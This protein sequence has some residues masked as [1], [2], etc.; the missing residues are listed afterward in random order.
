MG[1]HAEGEEPAVVSS[2]VGL[3]ALS[4][5]ATGMPPYGIRARR[6]C[7]RARLIRD[8]FHARRG[9]A[10]PTLSVIERR[11]LGTGSHAEREDA[12][13]DEFASV[14]SRIMTL[15]LF[16]SIIYIGMLG[17]VFGPASQP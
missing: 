12:G 10:S 17:P 5:C 6:G 3:R 1:S 9:M 2:H 13:A 8:S 11:A 16:S 4:F 14:S 15:F 7:H